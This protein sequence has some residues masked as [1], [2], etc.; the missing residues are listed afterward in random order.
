M[1]ARRCSRSGPP[2]KATWRRSPRSIA[3][4][5]ST[6]SRRSRKSRQ[7]ADELARRR[8]EILAL[9]PAVSGR[10]AV[11]TC[12]RLLLRLPY[13]T[14]SA[15]R[16]TLED[17]IY[18]DAAEVGR[19]I[20]RALLSALIERCSELGYRQMVAVIGGSDTVAV[21]PPARG[22]RLYANRPPAR[23]RFQIRQLG[24]HRPDAA[25]PRPR[26]NDARR[27]G[28]VRQRREAT[29]LKRLL[30]PP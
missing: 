21:D 15:Y 28:P 18:V 9:G 14:R 5:S 30:I 20:G 22:A 8:R 12:S 7:S 13:R 10:R 27:R 25:C 2:A 4:M 23:G 3:I 29:W 16:F 1:S 19:G 6:V 17:S 11:G 26:R 24:R